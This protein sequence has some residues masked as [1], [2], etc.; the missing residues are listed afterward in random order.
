V[1]FV[2]CPHC[3]LRHSERSDRRCPRCRAELDA[4]PTTEEAPAPY[5][6]P[7]A[8]LAPPRPFSSFREPDEETIPLGARIAGVVLVLNAL[9]SFYTSFVLQVSLAGPNRFVSAVVDLILGGLLVLGQ[10]KVVPLCL[11]RVVLG[12]LFFLGMT[13]Y[14]GDVASAS[15]QFALSSSLLGLLWG[16]PGT[17]RLALS[18]VVAAAYLLSAGILLHMGTRVRSA[19]ALLASN[20]IEAIGEAG[21][22][23]VAFDYRFE[24]PSAQWYVRSQE[25]TKRENAVADQW[26]VRPDKDA[27]FIIIVESFG[28][29]AV[30]VA[31]YENAVLENLRNAATR[32]EVLETGQLF[33]SYEQSRRVR[34]RAA[35]MGMSI[36]YLYGLVVH[37]GQGYQFIGFAGRG[38]FPSVAPE[39]QHMF[40]TLVI[41]ER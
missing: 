6:S 28:G 16:T 20:D 1:N 12:A 25:V 27:H 18:S 4:S 31:N 24:A 15:M 30:D 14:S 10:R 3:G 32:V 8:S 22:Q 2:R 39:F 11:V 34:A 29:Q 9:T 38:E 7:S 17:A 23:G 5:R 36:D 33:E 37:G 35:V 19:D 41:G 21:V 40:D 26:L 13:I